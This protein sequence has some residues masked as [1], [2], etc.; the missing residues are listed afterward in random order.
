M[1]RRL[2][3]FDRSVQ[4][5][6]VN[7]LTINTG[8]YMLMPYLA[9]H[10][11]D[12]LGMAAWSVGLIL[13][14]RNLSQQGMFL[15]GGTLA[16]R[17]GYRP[18]ILA[19]CLLRTAG[20]A[21]LAFAA[22]LPALLIASAM[23]GF[24]G[25]LFNPAVRAYLAHDAGPRRVEAF[26]LFNVFYQVGIL[27]GPPIGL[28]LAVVDFRLVC[29]VAAGTFALLTMLQYLALPPCRTST[30]PAGPVLAD[31]RAVITNRPF[32]LFTL[33]MAGS[34][35]LSFQVYLALPLE[36]DSSA[37]VSVLFV[38]SAVVAVV[39]QVRVTDWARRRWTGPQAIT[40]G[41]ACMAAAFLP[42]VVYGA[43]WP[44]SAPVRL[45]AVLACAVLL[46]LGTVLAYPFEMDRIVALSGDRMVA[47]HYG[48]YNMVAGIGIALGNL[49]TGLLVDIVP[50]AVPWLL[51]TALGL[52][53]LSAVRTLD[54]RGL[55]TPP[56][57]RPALI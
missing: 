13:G 27:I 3:S 25:A 50:G 11:S 36:L 44:G 6:M 12:G 34:Y 1:W 54:R 55:L 17:L 15:I 40:R 41:L 4:L 28:A 16:D 20:F 38:V 10:L 53:C 26:A 45:A 21:L 48:L 7:Q 18:V 23:T 39:G 37:A 19:G 5:L 31:W 33:A 42:L 51:L 46:A 9:G 32:M 52:V 14:M 47:T 8:F 2:R 22:N 35:T 57:E 49:V 30:P 43:L 29:L 24:A 56:S